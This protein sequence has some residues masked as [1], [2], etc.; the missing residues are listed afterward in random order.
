MN[1]PRRPDGPAIHDGKSYSAA[2]HLAEDVRP[3]VAMANGLRDRGFSA[4]EIHHA[5]L[6]AGFLITEDFGNA[7]SS[8][9]IHPRRSPRYE[10]A[11]DMLAAL[12]AKHAR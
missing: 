5:D 12:I 3:F 9:A 1:S 8:K 4:P 10:V 6:E 7:D 2:V 11:V